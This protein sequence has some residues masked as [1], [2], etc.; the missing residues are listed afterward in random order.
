MNAELQLSITNKIKD[1]LSEKLIG[2]D[3]FYT[4]GDVQTNVEFGHDY[5]D[6]TYYTYRS[7]KVLTDHITS[8][9]NRNLQIK[10][11]NN[12]MLVELVIGA[13]PFR[14]VVT[15]DNPEDI[16][17]LFTEQLED[18]IINGIIFD[19][20]QCLQNSIKIAKQ[21]LQDAINDQYEK[22]EQLQRYINA[23]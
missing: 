21:D 23:L 2:K 4:K 22:I 18:K 9:D 10:F 5:S 11:V 15:Y 13:N 8:L 20:E 7:C 12:K 14:V 6:T 3:A 19:Y 16:V 17:N 1:I